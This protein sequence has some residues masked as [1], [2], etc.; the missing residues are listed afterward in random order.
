MPKLRND[1]KLADY[2]AVSE[3]GSQSPRTRTKSPSPRGSTIHP[4]YRTNTIFATGTLY[5]HNKVIVKE[6]MSF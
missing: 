5:G 6:F 2:L 1:A 4:R 3:P